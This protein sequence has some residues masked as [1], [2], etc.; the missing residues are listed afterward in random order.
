MLHNSEFWD[1]LAIQS[2]KAILK[3]KPNDALVHKNLGLAYM[4]V[5]KINKAARSFQRAIKANKEFVEAYY[6]L[7]TAQQ[8][9]GRTTEAI[10]AFKKYKQLTQDLKGSAPVVTELLEQLKAQDT[11]S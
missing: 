1:E 8:A 3:S 10:R 2:Y 6:H 9:L 4:R 11:P 7:G 5:G